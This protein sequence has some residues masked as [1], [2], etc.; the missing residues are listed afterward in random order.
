MEHSLQSIGILMSLQQFWPAALQIA[1]L[2][3]YRQ[4]LHD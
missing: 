2:T 1:F 3:D 4:L